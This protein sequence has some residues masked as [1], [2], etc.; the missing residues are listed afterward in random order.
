MTGAAVLVLLSGMAGSWG[1]RNLL[2]KVLRKRHP[3]VFAALGA[4]GSRQLD[5]LH[6]RYRETQIKVWR[7][8]WGR[9]AFGLGDRTVAALAAGAMLA[10]VA[11][12]VG[13]VMLVLAARE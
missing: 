12:A 10:D 9:E 5:S 1:F 8:I 4:P 13:V 2:L 3:E 11:L 7:Y 6:P